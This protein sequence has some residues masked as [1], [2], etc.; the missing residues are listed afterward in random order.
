MRFFKKNDYEEYVSWFKDR[1]MSAP[2]FKFLPPTGIIVDQVAAGFM[3]E[4]DS[5]FVILDFFATNKNSDLGKRKEALDEIMKA[6][7]ELARSE[8]YDFIMC[9]SKIKRTND[10][11]LSHGFTGIGMYN[12]L[13]RE[14]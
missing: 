13:I 11:A 6:L 3:I 7:V 5:R 10:L 8:N 9:N 12:S 1:N 2:L 4:T 14:L